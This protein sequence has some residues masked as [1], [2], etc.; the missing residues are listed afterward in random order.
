MKFAIAALAAA[1]LAILSL[2]IPAPIFTSEASA[3][4]MN[5]KGSMCSEGMNCMSARYKAATSKAKKGTK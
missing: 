2:S 5:G 4:R 1:S 3:S